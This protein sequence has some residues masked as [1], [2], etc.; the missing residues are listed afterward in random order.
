MNNTIPEACYKFVDYN[1]DG[2]PRLKEL[3]EWDFDGWV[4]VA[5]IYTYGIPLELLPY[6]E[7][8]WENFSDDDIVSIEYITD[9]KLKLV[10]LTMPKKREPYSTMRV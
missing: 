9:T 10:T 3:A 4:A 8:G 1:G 2:L 7:Y 5:D 6:A